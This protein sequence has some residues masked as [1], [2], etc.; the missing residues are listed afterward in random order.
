MPQRSAVAVQPSAKTVVALDLGS[1][2]FHLLVAQCLDGTTTPLHRCGV[3]VQLLAGKQSGQLHEDA[4]QRG[5]SCI[6]E[7]VD[8]LEELSY[9]VC[10]VVGT[11]ALR[12]ADNAARFLHPAEE[13]LGEPIEVIDGLQEAEL[14]YAGVLSTS[15]DTRPRLVIDVGGGSTELIVGEGEK[16]HAAHSI[17]IGCVA[18]MDQFFANGEISPQQFA[19]AVSFVEQQFAPIA[20][21]FSGFNWQQALGCSGTLQAVS[22]VLSACGGAKNTIEAH[23]LLPLRDA[24]LQYQHI[25]QLDFAGLL[26]SRRSVF[27]SGL[28]IVIGL[29]AAFQLSSLSI[30]RG[31]L[32]EGIVYHLSRDL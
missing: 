1:N 15:V 4:I 22:Q 12:D 5:L 16:L 23:R 11:S 29:F 6:A 13:L 10:R 9:D 3:K 17:N 24:L 28:A 30:S 14:I 32:R 27:A 18:L 25:G 21:E 2:S 31:A 19:A 20:S 7:F 26:E 8:V